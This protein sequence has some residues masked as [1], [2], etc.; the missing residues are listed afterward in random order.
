MTKPSAKDDG[1]TPAGQ[2]KQLLA[3][4]GVLFG[5]G[6]GAAVLG[7][8][9]DLPK[10]TT[11]VTAAIAAIAWVIARH[12]AKSSKRIRVGLLSLAV[13]IGAI[14]AYTIAH[15]DLTAMCGGERHLIGCDL[16]ADGE[17]VARERHYSGPVDMLMAFGCDEHAV[18]TSSS[19]NWNSLILWAT[20]CPLVAAIVFPVVYLWC[21]VSKASRS[22]GG[23]RH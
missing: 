22:R 4:L 20:F 19:L 21:V 9:S 17:R 6:A 11:A 5:G 14:S 16:T 13:L 2:A 12:L 10:L 7:P 8:P 1:S 23:S 18:W 3:L 15:G